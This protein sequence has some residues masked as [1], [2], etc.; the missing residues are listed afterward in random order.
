[1][2]KKIITNLLLIFCLASCANNS[3]KESP[4]IYISNLS[5]QR[6]DNIQIKFPKQ[7]LKLESLEPG[8]TRGQSFITNDQNDFFGR[9]FVK[10][11]NHL[12]EDVYKSFT[13]LPNEMPSYFNP[14]VFNFV[15]IYLKDF[16]AEI[17]TFD[18][19]NSEKILTNYDVILKDLYT[20]YV[21]KNKIA[22]RGSGL[23]SY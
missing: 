2:I 1:M 10:W 23:I 13:L 6:F 18:T 17:V 4:T 14:K 11:K 15:Q 9:I 21:V 5:S 3:K 12:G 7:I 8:L 19:P 20:L 16:D 22:I